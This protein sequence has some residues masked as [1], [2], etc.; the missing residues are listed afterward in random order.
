MRLTLHP[1]TF[2]VPALPV[3]LH[4]QMHLG[5]RVDGKGGSHALAIPPELAELARR[6]AAAAS[7]ADASLPD[8]EPNVCVINL[9]TAG[10]K[11]FCQLPL[12]I[13]LSSQN[14]DFCVTSKLGEHADVLTRSDAGVPVVSVSLGL[15]CDFEFRRGYGKKKPKRSLVLHSGDALVFGGRSRSIL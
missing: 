14:P 12:R 4:P 8:L 10:S 1:P 11:V 15:S 2:T 9:Y 6:V 13:V 5:R 3:T 7:A